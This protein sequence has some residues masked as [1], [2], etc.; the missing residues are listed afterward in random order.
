ME[1]EIAGGQGLG[2]E[3]RAH[4]SLASQECP[5]ITRI[6]KMGPALGLITGPHLSS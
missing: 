1:V 4:R 2:T 6:I 3:V 5:L